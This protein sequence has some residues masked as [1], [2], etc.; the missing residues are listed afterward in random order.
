MSQAQR[1]G[2]GRERPETYDLSTG[3]QARVDDLVGAAGLLIAVA[4]LATR[5]YRRVRTEPP[6]PGDSAHLKLRQFKQATTAGLDAWR[7]AAHPDGSGSS[8]EEVGDERP[9]VAAR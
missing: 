7:N 4:V 3:W 6:P 5:L 2:E 8:T 9:V 1:S